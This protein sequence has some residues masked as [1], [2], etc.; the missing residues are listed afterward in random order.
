MLNNLIVAYEISPGQPTEQ[1][2]VIAIK[3]LGDATRLLQ[4]VWHIQSNY[5]ANEAADRIRSAM[6]GHDRL[7]VFDMRNEEIAWFNLI[8]KSES[9]LDRI[10]RR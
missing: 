1:A 9:L 7:A 8:D 2:V 3:E 4:T 6:A 5:S 10:W